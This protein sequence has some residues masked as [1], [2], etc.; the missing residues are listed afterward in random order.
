MENS[1]PATDDLILVFDENLQCLVA[2]DARSHY[3]APGDPFCRPLESVFSKDIDREHVSELADRCRRLLERNGTGGHSEK[4]EVDSFGALMIRMTPVSVAN[5][6]SKGVAVVLSGMSGLSTASRDS[7]RAAR[8]RLEFVARM[9][10]EMRVPVGSVANIA[11]SLLDASL[12]GNCPRQ[13]AEELGAAATWLL[14]MVNDVTDIAE[15]ETNR[16]GLAPAPF[17]LRLFLDNVRFLAHHLASQKG[18]GFHGEFADNIPDVVVCDEA[19]LR[20]ALVNLIDNAVKF[21]KSGSIGFHASASPGQLHFAVSDTGAGIAPNEHHR[22]SAHTRESNHG[23]GVSNGFGLF[24]TRSIVDLMG[25]KVTVLSEKGAGSTFSFSI[26][27][28]P[29][30]PGTLPSRISQAAINHAPRVLVVDDNKINLSV[31]VGMLKAQFG[32]AADQADSGEAALEMIGRTAYALIL[33]DHMMPGMD[34]VETT[35]CIRGRGGRNAAVPVVALTANAADGAREMLLAAGLDD[36]L[37]KPLRRA[38]LDRLLRKWMPASLS[39]PLKPGDT[40]TCQDTVLQPQAG[41]R[42][43]CEKGDKDDLMCELADLQRELGE[44]DLD[45]IATRLEP[46][47]LLDYGPALTPLLALVKEKVDAF[48]YE[49]ARH[50]LYF[51]FP[52]L[53]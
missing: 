13:L 35:Q 8:A 6:Q 53:R 7:E 48:D 32:I 42:S 45:A 36:F 3:L 40:A 12:S 39:H 17:D 46:L 44:Y 38:D 24:I 1:R 21:T 20:Q 11:V 18:L 51:H 5:G 50:F 23:D 16:F 10:R 2:S 52:E 34:G 15:L 37:S 43:R 4:M 47:T 28:A 26:P 31:A 22:L 25:G 33:M 19:R 41:E 29:V 30:A 9:G 27:L 49:G 14:A